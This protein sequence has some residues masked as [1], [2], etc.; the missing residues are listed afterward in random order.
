MAL[1]SSFQRDGFPA[2]HLARKYRRVLICS[3]GFTDTGKSE[4][5]MSAPAPGI[6]ICID[7]GIDGMLDNPSPPP[8]RQEDWA[9]KVVPIPAATQLAS[10]P[11]Y[12]PYWKEFYDNNYKKALGNPDAR[13]V[14]VDGD[15][16]TWELQRLAEF[17]RLTQIPSIMY[18]NVNAARRVMVARAYD[19][20]KNVIFTNKLR[21]LYE[22]MYDAQGQ[23]ILD[24][25]GRPK[26]EWKGKWER[27]GFDDNDYL[28]QI[29]LLHKYRPARVV[30]T[31]KGEKEVPQA[32]GIQILKCK[33]QPALVGLDL[34]GDDCN[35]PTLVQTVYPDVTLKEWGL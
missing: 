28:I 5:A 13:T 34:W 2:L 4:F 6:H 32:W 15:S 10:A 14:V 35:F 30:K 22:P 8:T 24:E 27:Q 33:P 29:S 7:R 1:P 3:E 16:D 12:L 11:E 17:G 18:T 9:V 19:S 20:G 31:P 21:K 25:K 26:R 23:P